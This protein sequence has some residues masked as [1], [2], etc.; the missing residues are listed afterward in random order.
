MLV[1]AEKWL[2]M[3]KGYVDG[4]A[5]QVFKANYINRGIIV[6]EGD[7][8]VTFKF[9]SSYFDVGK[10]ISL[11]SLFVIF[12]LLGQSPFTKFIKTK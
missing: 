8:I 9:E 6:P 11:F 1:L 2:P 3:W 7:H 4:K 10:W 12:V 5:E